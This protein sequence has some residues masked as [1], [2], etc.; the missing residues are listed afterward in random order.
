MGAHRGAVF[1]DAILHLIEPQPACAAA[2]AGVKDVRPST[3]IHAVAVTRPG[4]RRV[5]MTGG[6]I[7]GERGRPRDR[8]G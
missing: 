1:P 3:Q 7:G 8:R 4:T 5:R 2:L 6:R